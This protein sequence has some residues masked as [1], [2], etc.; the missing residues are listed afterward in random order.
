MAEQ[1]SAQQ[2][3]EL[4]DRFLHLATQLADY[5]ITNSDKLTDAER[6]KIHSQA[7]T[8]LRQSSDMTAVAIG[9]TLEGLAET[10]D[11]TAQA[12]D[13]MQQ[14]I[15]RLDKPNKVL[16]IAAAAVKLGAAIL[17]FNPMAIVGALRGAQKAA[18]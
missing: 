18:T 15:A 8:L 12:T 10:L 6:V 11:Q 5:C 1:L 16:G 7:S 2:A 9:K 13:Q 4:A 14:A 17:T 3:R